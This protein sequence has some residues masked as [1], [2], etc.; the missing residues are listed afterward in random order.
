M[1]VLAKT[2]QYSECQF[3][4]HVRGYCGLHTGAYFLGPLGSW[5]VSQSTQI[6][7]VFE[8][9][10]MN[11]EQILLKANLKLHDSPFGY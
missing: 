7:W 1:Q 6:F 9:S 3:L 5:E 2:C 11:P 10:T 4:I 8:G